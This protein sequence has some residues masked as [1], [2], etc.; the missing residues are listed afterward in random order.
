MAGSLGGT[1]ASL[2][3]DMGLAL[4]DGYDL[5]VVP[6]IGQGSVKDVEDRL[7]LRL[8][9]R[10]EAEKMER[11]RVRAMRRIESGLWRQ[12]VTRIAGVDEVGVGP[13]AGPVVAAAVVFPRGA[14]IDGVDDSKRL[15]P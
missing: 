13:M 11:R 14:A 5:R 8:R 2:A 3:A 10:C 7:Y 15:E 4:S 6:M 12:G 1:D 9:K